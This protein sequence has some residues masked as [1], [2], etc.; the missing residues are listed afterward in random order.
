MERVDEE[1]VGGNICDVVAVV[2]CEDESVC[3]ISLEFV[4]ICVISGNPV[5]SPFVKH[6]VRCGVVAGEEVG[7]TS[8]GDVEGSGK[9]V[10]L[11]FPCG[12]NDVNPAG[13]SARHIVVYAKRVNTVPVT[14]N[15][16]EWHTEDQQGVIVVHRETGDHGRRS[17]GVDEGGIG[18]GL[19]VVA[20]ECGSEGLNCFLVDHLFVPF[21]PLE[22]ILLYH[23]SW[24]KARV[25][26][27]KNCK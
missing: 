18:V 14:E 17:G 3:E 1:E 24:E 2:V 6:D 21:Y 27:G 23:I 9:E 5:F 13:Y 11:D 4:E 20:L 7:E 12:V 22:D 10:D 26:P 16:M 25:F 8:G 19:L 15:V